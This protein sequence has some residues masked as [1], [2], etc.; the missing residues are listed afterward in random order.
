MR[1]RRSLLEE[2][3]NSGDESAKEILAAFPEDYFSVPADSRTLND[4]V[5]DLLQQ[6]TIH[7]KNLSCAQHESGKFEWRILLL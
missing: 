3:E 2:D 1:K 6:F 7:F 5:L 4:K